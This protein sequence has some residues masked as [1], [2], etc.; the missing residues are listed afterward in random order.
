M[1]AESNERRLSPSI[2]LT[3]CRRVDKGIGVEARRKGTRRGEIGDSDS[4][5]VNVGVVQ[6]VGS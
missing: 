3:A 6:M 5:I 1:Y 2:S 4:S